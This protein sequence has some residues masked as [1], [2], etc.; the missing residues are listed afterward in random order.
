[1]IAE[2]TPRWSASGSRLR[3]DLGFPLDEA[4]AAPAALA[5]PLGGA[6]AGR[7]GA[8][9]AIRLTAEGWLLLD[10]LAVDFAAAGGSRPTRRRPRD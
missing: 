9:G 5:R 3:T 7:A 4:D 1:M 2:R 6:R 10:R 8:A